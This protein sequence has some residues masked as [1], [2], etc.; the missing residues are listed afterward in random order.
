MVKDASKLENMCFKKTQPPANRKFSITSEMLMVLD[1]IDE[2][3]NILQ[4]HSEVQFPFH[5]FREI[6][7]LLLNIGLIEPS[8]RNGNGQYLDR[9]SFLEPM[10]IHLTEA[11]G[12][13]ADFILAEV[14]SDMEINPNRIPVDQAAEVILNVSKE[15]MDSEMKTKFQKTMIKKIPAK[16]QMPQ[17]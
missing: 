7:L 4:L 11:M 10:K 17:K 6:L 3:K 9:K 5:Q 1:K 14:F 15:I 13:V 2:S 16:K 8:G 12:P